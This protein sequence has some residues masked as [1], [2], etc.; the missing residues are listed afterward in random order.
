MGV[1]DLVRVLRALACSGSAPAAE[2]GRLRLTC[3]MYQRA[4][5]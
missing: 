2:Q 4:G 1:L 5:V 3:V